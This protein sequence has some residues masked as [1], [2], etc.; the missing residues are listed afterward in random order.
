MLCRKCL[1]VLKGMVKVFY[2]RS[3]CEE[4]FAKLEAQSRGRRLPK[5]PTP[6]VDLAGLQF[7]SLGFNFAIQPGEGFPGPSKMVLGI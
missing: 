2:G 6:V 5:E 1:R 3:V 4:C 7:Y